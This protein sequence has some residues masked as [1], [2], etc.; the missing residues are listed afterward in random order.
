[1]TPL[2]DG[3]F[4][5][6]TSF[7]EMN[8]AV[9]SKPEDSS[10][11]CHVDPGDVRL[12]GKLG[13]PMSTNMNMK[14]D[15]NDYYVIYAPYRTYA[16]CDAENKTLRLFTLENVE[17][18]QQCEISNLV[19]HFNISTVVYRP[20]HDID[21]FEA[22][23]REIVISAKTQHPKCQR[24]K[25]II[26]TGHG[27]SNGN[28]I[29][30]DMSRVTFNEI[31]ECLDEDLQ[32][33]EGNRLRVIF[34]MCY[35]HIIDPKFTDPNCKLDVISLTNSTHERTKSKID[36]TVGVGGKI[37]VKDARHLDLHQH[38]ENNRNYYF[39]EK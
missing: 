17:Q 34:A 37:D 15:M 30:A 23:L 3:S 36:S 10:T 33:Y 38:F 8:S 12:F 27:T 29:L 39:P 1:M 16:S 26:F 32:K 2:S 13:D 31:L 11:T 25:V 21:E 19:K 20:V 22:A 6:G 4:S 28:F 5:F 18:I 35:S 7:L 24:K 14:H 9:K